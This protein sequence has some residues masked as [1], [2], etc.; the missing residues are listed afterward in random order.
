MKK[1]ICISM[2]PAIYDD[3]HQ[4]AT[5]RNVP[6]SRIIEERVQQKIHCLD[7]HKFYFPATIPKTDFPSIP[8]TYP[9]PKEPC[10]N[11]KGDLIT[12]SE[13]NQILH[14]HGEF[15]V[16]ETNGNAFRL[17]YHYPLG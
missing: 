5:T 14:D 13:A 9:H 2:H 10:I 4:E 8:I 12:F 3:I 1:K 11:Y 7:N 6:L 15:G 16:Y 17:K